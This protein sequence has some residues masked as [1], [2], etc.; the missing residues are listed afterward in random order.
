V[1]RPLEL[2]LRP[3]R[4]PVLGGD[5]RG[6]GVGHVG[7]APGLTGAQEAVEQRCD[8]DEGGSGGALCMSSLREW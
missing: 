1:A 6:G 4:L 5:S 8:G 2:G 7:L 3:L